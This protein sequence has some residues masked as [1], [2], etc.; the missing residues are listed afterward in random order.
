M[1]FNYSIVN[2]NKNKNNPLTRNATLRATV[3]RR[4]LR[5]CKGWANTTRYLKQREKKFINLLLPFF[6]FPSS[7][8]EEIFRNGKTALLEATRLSCS[9]QLNRGSGRK[10]RVTAPGETFDTPCKVN[11]RVSPPHSSGDT[12]EIRIGGGSWRKKGG[13][14]FKGAKIIGGHLLPARV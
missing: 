3:T 14:T 4:L 2:D 10:A 9:E 5:S 11:F 13:V 1:Y 8:E 12:I 7:S 6:L